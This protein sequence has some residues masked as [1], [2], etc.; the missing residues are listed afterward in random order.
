[1]NASGAP[2][3]SRENWSARRSTE[4]DSRLAITPIGA[5]TAAAASASAGSAAGV[6]RSSLSAQLQRWTAS[7]AAGAMIAANSTVRGT[8]RWRTWPSSWAT[9]SRI[10]SRE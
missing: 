9:T 10:S 1:M 5:L 7:A 4:R 6:P 3:S 2:A 8:S